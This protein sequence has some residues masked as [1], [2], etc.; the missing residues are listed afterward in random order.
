MICDLR[1]SN[2]GSESCSVANECMCCITFDVQ[3]ADPVPGE[4]GG[5]PDVLREIKEA[6]S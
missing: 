3:G 6:I 5:R 2:T 4:L 1:R